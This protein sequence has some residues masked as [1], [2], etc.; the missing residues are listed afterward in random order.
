[1]LIAEERI[2]AALDR[3]DGVPDRLRSIEAFGEAAQVEVLTGELLLRDGR[4]DQ[5][6]RL[7]GPVLA[8]LPTG[9]RPAAQAAWL[10]ARALDDQDRPAE[11]A[12]IRAEHGIGEE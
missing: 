4:P 9:S 11:A 2:T 7:L 3:L 8:G 12:K 1:V 5:A 10:L 6:E